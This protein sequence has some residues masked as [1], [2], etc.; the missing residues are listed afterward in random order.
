MPSLNLQVL[1]D[2]LR[3]EVENS[4]SG[5]GSRGRQFSGAQC[6][7]VEPLNGVKTISWYLKNIFETS[8][9]KKSEKGDHCKFLKV[10]IYPLC[11]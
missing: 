5:E 10:R 3:T 7:G 4:G 8:R 1:N 9:G 2:D 11:L 6:L